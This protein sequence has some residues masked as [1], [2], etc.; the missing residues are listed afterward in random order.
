MKIIQALKLEV[1]SWSSSSADY[2]LCVLGQVTGFLL[3]YWALF[4]SSQEQTQC[5]QS[6]GWGLSALPDR[7]P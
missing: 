7:N 3:T 1:L 2:L 6:A 4:C 5:Y